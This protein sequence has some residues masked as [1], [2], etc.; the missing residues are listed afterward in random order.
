MSNSLS[1]VQRIFTFLKKNPRRLVGVG[2]EKCERGDIKL[3]LFS[4][5]GIQGVCYLLQSKVLY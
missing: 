2:K 5:I 4:E 1:L 3:E